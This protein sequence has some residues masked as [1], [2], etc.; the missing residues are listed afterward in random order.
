L[1]YHFELAKKDKRYLSRLLAH[2]QH[3]NI[4]HL[5]LM[6]RLKLI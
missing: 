6:A 4:Y 3:G 1:L 5:F 2:D